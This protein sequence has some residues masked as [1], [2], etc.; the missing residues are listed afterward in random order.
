MHKTPKEQQNDMLA[1][2]LSSPVKLQKLYIHSVCAFN[3]TQFQ[4]LVHIKIRQ[5]FNACFSFL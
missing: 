2:Q 1:M 3:T 5:T 4:D